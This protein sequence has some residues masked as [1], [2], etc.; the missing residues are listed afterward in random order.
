MVRDEYAQAFGQQM[1]D[2]LAGNPTTVFVESG[3]KGKGSGRWS[4]SRTPSLNADWFQRFDGDRKKVRKA[5]VRLSKGKAPNLKQKE[6]R[7]LMT[8]LE[9]ARKDGWAATIHD[10]PWV[11]E[12]PPEHEWKALVSK[13]LDLSSAERG[14]LCTNT[15]GLCRAQFS[16]RKAHRVYLALPESE[17]SQL[18]AKA[19]AVHATPNRYLAHVLASWHEIDAQASREF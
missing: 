13:R 3:E 2:S 1:L 4:Y 6:G 10:K 16:P 5:I 14:R 7:W 15:K 17:Y 12:I 11:G 9:R 18:K 8:A 19:A